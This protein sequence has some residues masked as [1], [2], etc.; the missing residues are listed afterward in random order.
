MIELVHILMLGNKG[1]VACLFL[2]GRCLDGY[3]DPIGICPAR[4]RLNAIIDTSD[5]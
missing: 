5:A 4:V 2:K 3:Y 1:V